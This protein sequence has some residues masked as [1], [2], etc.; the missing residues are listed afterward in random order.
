MYVGDVIVQLSGAETRHRMSK[1]EGYL[2]PCRGKIDDFQTF[3]AKFDVLATIKK[4][5]TEEKKMA[6]LPLFLEQDAFL[7]FS[8]MAADDK[9]SSAA[10]KKKLQDAFCMSQSEAFQRFKAR[11]MGLE[12]SPDAYVADLQRLACLAGDGASGSDDNHAVVDLA[13]FRMPQRS[14]FACVLWARIRL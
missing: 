2:R 8:R 13:I 12:E 3:W 4:W 7:V 14:R 9:K 10:V 5:D 1:A 6:Q 11:R